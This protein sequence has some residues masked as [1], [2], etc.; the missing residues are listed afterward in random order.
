MIRGSKFEIEH[1]FRGG[2]F[3]NEQIYKVKKTCEVLGKYMFL[4]RT[5]LEDR[6][7]ERI[8]LSYI[9]KCIN[10]NIIA[11]LKHNGYDGSKDIYYYQLDVGGYNLLERAGI[12]HNEMNILADDKVKSRILTFNYFIKN[13][14]MDVDRDYF[15]PIHHTYF[16]CKNSI[17]CYY[18]DK[19]KET[20]I[21]KILQ[22][23]LT[24][25]KDGEVREPSIEELRERFSFRQID[26]ELINVGETSKTTKKTKKNEK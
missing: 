15:Q 2:I 12:R 3:N 6:A 24:E 9:G 16:F 7:G 1:L 26:M 21:L 4:D 8:G 18:E 20:K 17:I 25:K 19:I 23:M 22:L 14:N 5:L 10:Y 11:Q 13:N